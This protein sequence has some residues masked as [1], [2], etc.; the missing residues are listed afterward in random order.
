M[1]QDIAPH[2]YHVEFTPEE[3]MDDSPVFVF[4]GQEMLLHSETRF[5]TKKDLESLQSGCTN[6]RLI[7]LFK[8]DDLSYYLLE[9]LPQELSDAPQIHRCPTWKLRSLPDM[10][11]SFAGYTAW[12]LWN[13]YSSNRFCSRCGRPMTHG[14]CERSLVCPACGQ[15]V[16]PRIN[17]AVIC[18]VYDGDRLLMTKYAN[19][20]VTWFVLVAGFM[21][22]GEA[23]E[24]TVRREV[25]E[26]TGVH[27]KNIRYF[28][29]QPWGIPG[30]LTL[31]F[32]AQLDGDDTVT[33]DTSEL[34][35]AKWIPREEVEVPKDHL[36]I[37]AA[38]I[39]AFKN[40][41]Y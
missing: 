14:N 16:Y 38:M 33:V 29:S 8:I 41:E 40:G 30:N 7:W 11:M 21:E 19:R 9:N 26:E 32:T 10:A 20:P 6:D 18:A 35:E 28:G 24:D 34:A 2:Q 12:H 3:A 27:V 36:S 25:L 22:I 39:R 15:T 37:T 17:P 31:G 23:A 5:L 4:S 1:I 13:W